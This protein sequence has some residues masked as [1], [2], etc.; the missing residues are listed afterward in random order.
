MPQER[1]AELLQR[2]QEACGPHTFLLRVYAAL[3]SAK[4]GDARMLAGH[5][6]DVAA[7]ALVWQERTINDWTHHYKPPNSKAA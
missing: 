7:A 2:E 1:R 5:L 6:E 3:E 4:T